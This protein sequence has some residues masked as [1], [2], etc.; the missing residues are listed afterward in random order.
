M[1]MNSAPKRLPLE[2]P[3]HSVEVRGLPIRMGGVVGR[4]RLLAL[5]AGGVASLCAGPALA[6]TAVM[7]RPRSFHQRRFDNVVRQVLE[8]SCGSASLATV[9]TFFLSRPTTEAEVIGILKERYP[10]F[11]KWKEKSND[12]FSFEDIIF[13]ADQLGFRSEAARVGIEQLM[14]LDG[15]VIV[16]LNKGTWQ[17]FTVLR[18]FHQGFAYLADPING[19]VTILAEE[20]AQEYTGSALA[21]W[22]PRKRLS[23]RSPLQ[24][25]RNGLRTDEVLSGAINATTRQWNHP[26]FF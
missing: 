5:F 13:A 9:L 17:H 20:F 26:P 19:Q 2:K 4:R 15:P 21:V 25:V 23:K 3:S 1:D 24:A 12:G 22:D 16:H 8:F 11:E 18:R 14:R 7:Q 6:D 10:T